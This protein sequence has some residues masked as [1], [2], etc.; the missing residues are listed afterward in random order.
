MENKTIVKVLL[1]FAVWILILFV[2]FGGISILK[3]IACLVIS[4][5]IMIAPLE[6]ILDNKKPK[7][8]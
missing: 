2:G 6:K 1:I 4:A 5:G 7:H 3:I 8:F